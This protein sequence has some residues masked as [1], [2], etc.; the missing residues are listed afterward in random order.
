MK[1]LS[2]PFCLASLVLT[3]ASSLLVYSLHATPPPR[4]LFPKF[5]TPGSELQPV[6]YAKT[7]PLPSLIQKLQSLANEVQPENNQAQL[8]PVILGAF[9]GDPTL[10]SVSPD[11][12]STVIFFD[13]FQEKNA[14]FFPENHRRK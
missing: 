10:S 6:A 4:Q 8:L 2:L 1:I 14:H 5:E 7:I 3:S 12:S 11:H 9:L 13:D